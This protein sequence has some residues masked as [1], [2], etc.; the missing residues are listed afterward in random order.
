MSDTSIDP[1]IIEIDPVK[2][3]F[4]IKNTMVICDC[5]VMKNHIAE[6]CMTC[7]PTFNTTDICQRVSQL[8]SKHGLTPKVAPTV[9]K[10]QPTDLS[11]FSSVHTTP[12]KFQ[13]VQVKL[14][15]SILQVLYGGSR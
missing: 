12:W 8:N 10:V 5:Y 6:R 9:W 15:C 13:R 14:S 1:V 7:V 11:T 4:R 3:T 2:A